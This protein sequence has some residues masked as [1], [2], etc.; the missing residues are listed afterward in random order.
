M[1]TL[2]SIIVDATT[3]VGLLAGMIAVGGFLAHVVP[4]LRGR[5]EHELREAT[6]RGGLYGIVGALLVDLVALFQ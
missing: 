2:G 4:V 1:L 5:E 6:V 3:E